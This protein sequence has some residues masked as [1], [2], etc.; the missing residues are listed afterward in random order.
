MHFDNPKYKSLRLRAFYAVPK[1]VVI[2]STQALRK[3][4]LHTIVEST[5]PVDAARCN[6]VRTLLGSGA[7]RSAASLVLKW[8]LQKHFSPEE[9]VERLI[10]ARCHAAAL[11]FSRE[12]GLSSRH[13]PPTLLRS[14]L[15]GKQYES[16][17]KQV[18]KRTAS[19]DGEHSPSDVVRLMVSE[20]QH[21]LALKYVHKFGCGGLPA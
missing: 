13:P 3:Q 16:A 2:P 11:R 10:A 5:P 19:V 14:M 20:G 8:Q 9:I 21:A 6:L 7:V 17:L 4:K 1:M 12:F 18:G 15:E